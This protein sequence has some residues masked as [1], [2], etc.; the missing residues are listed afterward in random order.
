VTPAGLA[1]IASYADAI[2]PA[3]DLIVSRHPDGTLGAP[4]SLVADAHAAGLLVHAYTFRNENEFLPVNLRSAGFGADYGNAFAEYEVFFAAGV[5][6]VFADN[7]DTAL[8]A[9]A[10]V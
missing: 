4:T 1:E 8:V 6:G 2:G 9:R 5:D 10:A 3:K 7:P